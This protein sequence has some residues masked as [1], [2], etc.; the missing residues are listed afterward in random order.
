M[1]T[2]GFD[3]GGTFTDLALLDHASGS[4]QV[5]KVP[6][7]ANNPAAAVKAGLKELGV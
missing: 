2:L 5:T 1:L 4:V 3:I 7:N 6:S